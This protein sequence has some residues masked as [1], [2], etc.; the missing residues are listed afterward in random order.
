MGTAGHTHSPRSPPALSGHCS[1]AWAAPPPPPALGKRWLAS[2]KTHCC[3]PP[4]PSPPWKPGELRRGSP[5]PGGWR[6]LT[7]L[8]SHVGLS[9]WTLPGTG[10]ASTCN[11]NP[12]AD[13][14]V[15]SRAIGPTPDLG[16]LTRP[17]ASA[18]PLEAWTTTCPHTLRAAQGQG[19][20]QLC[21]EP[22]LCCVWGPAA[23]PTQ[24]ETLCELRAQQH[25]RGG[26]GWGPG[27]RS[28]E[29]GRQTPPRGCRPP[30][31][32]AKGPRAHQ[33]PAVFVP[34]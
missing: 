5:G 6:P 18:H 21:G 23:K 30:R 22:R 25:A 9:S 33:P 1:P 11:T 29:S 26:S 19:A 2:Q 31:S 7:R 17:E 10:E 15:A 34:A 27:D 16:L 28:R 20:G 13:G 12:Q 14:W 32:S 8:A 3:L 24:Q 4:P